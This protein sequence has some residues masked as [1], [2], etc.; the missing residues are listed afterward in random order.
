[1]RAAG[2]WLRVSGAPAAA[3][4][5]GNLTKGDEMSFAR[6]VAALIVCAGL[7][8][9]AP[10]SAAAAYNPYTPKEVCGSAFD[11]I[12][13][14]AIRGGGVHLADTY[15]MYHAG[16]NCVATIKRAYVGKRSWTEAW[17]WRRNYGNLAEDQGNFKYYAGPVKRWANNRCVAFGGYA[18]APDDSPRASVTTGF[19]WCD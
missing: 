4:L 15:L 1:L 3:A 18:S 7:F 11:V 6:Y 19:G 8:A 16:R 13:K 5:R 14:R 10:A 12:A 17:L 9:A 2:S